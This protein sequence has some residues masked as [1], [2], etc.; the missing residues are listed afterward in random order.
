MLFSLLSTV[1]SYARVYFTDAAL[2]EYSLSLHFS[3]LYVAL[4]FY[5]NLSIINCI[6]DIVYDR[7][8]CFFHFVLLFLHF[9]RVVLQYYNYLRFF[10]LLLLRFPAS[11]V[12]GVLLG[13]SFKLSFFFTPS[14]LTFIYIYIYMHIALLSFEALSRM[15]E[16]RPCFFFQSSLHLSVADLSQHCRRAL[17]CRV[18]SFFFSFQ[19]ISVDVVFNKYFFLLLP[20]A[21][22]KGLDRHPSCTCKPHLN[23]FD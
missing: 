9:T 22:V 1:F 4:F 10:F 3:I 6:S 18:S 21:H 13:Y 11:Q 17:M 5:F 14:F 15:P 8:L 12:G 16:D 7:S 23:T 2:S 19:V 20:F